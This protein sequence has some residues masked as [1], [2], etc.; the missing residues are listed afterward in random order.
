MH[1]SSVPTGHLQ[2]PSATGHPCPTSLQKELQRHTQG[3]GVLR[4]Y[5]L[6]ELQH[7]LGASRREGGWLQR[8]MALCRGRQGAFTFLEPLHGRQVAAST[9]S[10]SKMYNFP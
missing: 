1:F 5:S 8:R 2:D 6:K 9:Q 10:W 3:L 7:L 4:G